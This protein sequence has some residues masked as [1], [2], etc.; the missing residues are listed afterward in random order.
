MVTSHRRGRPIALL[1]GLHG[2]WW[3][4]WL[5]GGLCVCVWTGEF[6][7]YFLARIFVT[8]S[9]LL[10]MARSTRAPLAAAPLLVGTRRHSHSHSQNQKIKCRILAVR[11]SERE[12]KTQTQRVY[13]CVSFLLFK[14]TLFFQIGY[15]SGYT[16]R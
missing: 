4:L 13:V 11:S 12:G 7:I 1:R 10:M 8:H 14:K 16:R 15:H 5:A 6:F 2:G 9:S 3:P